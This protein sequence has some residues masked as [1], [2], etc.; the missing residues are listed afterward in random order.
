MT[1]RK[2]S[3][4][5]RHVKTAKHLSHFNEEQKNLVL[6]LVEYFKG[7]SIKGKDGIR[8]NSCGGS[9]KTFTVSSVCKDM[10]DVVCLAPT[11]KAASVLRKNGF[12]AKTF[13][14]FFGWGMNVDENNN[15]YSVWDI[16]E[17]P[18]ETIFIIDEIS[19]M[20][21]SQFSLFKHY[22]YDKYKYVLLGDKY[23]LPPFE[24]KAKDVLPNGVRYINNKTKDVSLFFQFECIDFELEKNMRT[25]NKDLLL[26]ISTMRNKVIDNKPIVLQ[27]NWEFNDS[28]FEQI[29]NRDYIVICHKNSD[30]DDFN[31][32]IRKIFNPT[33]KEICV[34]DKI[35]LTK[36]HV[37]KTTEGEFEYLLNGY[38]ATVLSVQDY[39]FT[40]KKNVLK[41]SDDEIVQFPG[42]QLYLDDDVVVK[43]IKNDYKDA[44]RQF[45]K[46]TNTKVKNLKIKDLSNAEL[47]KKKIALFK[48][49][50][51][52]N[53]QNCE[54]NF[55]FSSTINKA[56][57]SSYD[58]V[59]VYNIDNMYFGNKQKYTACSRVVNELY[60][61]SK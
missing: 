5:Y 11:N 25:S 30:V 22:I 36:F 52:F 6:K 38:R 46:S 4:F 57:G 14:S 9:G 42:F 32:R 24:P 29:Q 41:E 10:N 54:F 56:Q 1:F 8:V 59:F 37:A 19:M 27:N 60:V 3:E 35:V 61:F 34:G 7:N 23:Q 39:T 16:P 26:K 28:L 55:G 47:S 45:I 44:F 53:A 48:Q 31:K 2:L 51:S 50:R 13:H 33:D 21:E 12:K 17:I 20:T 43:F 18:N 40:F 58:I 15:E 49:I